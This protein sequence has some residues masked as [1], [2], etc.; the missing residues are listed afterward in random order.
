MSSEIELVAC[1][2]KNRHV[3]L[4]CM[5]YACAHKGLMRKIICPHVLLHNHSRGRQSDT[6]YDNS[7]FPSTR[8]NLSP[9]TKDFRGGEQLYESID[10][11]FFALAFGGAP[12]NKRDLF[13]AVLCHH[14][15][16]EKD[17]ALPAEC[18]LKCLSK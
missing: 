4:E 6:V 15:T 5:K 1:S 18:R 10:Q 12:K 9:F 14:R 2:V 16:R 13:V 3:T 17:A 8:I 7:G 11:F